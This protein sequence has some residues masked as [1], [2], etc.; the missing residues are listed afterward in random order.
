MDFKDAASAAKVA[1]ESAELASLAARA[2][3]ELSSRG[4]ISQ[5]SS[6]E[7][8]KSSSYNLR[9]EGPQGYASLNLRDQQLPKNQVISAP[10]KSSM[11]DD[12]WRD[13]DT[14]RFMGDDAKNF[15]YPSSSASNNDVNPSVTNFSAGDRY[16]FKNT[17]EPG[18]SDS[19]GSSATVEKQPRKFDANTS[20]TS[21]NAADR[22]SFKNSSEPGFSDSLDSVDKQP[23]RFDSNTS[24]SNSNE[25]DRYSLK[26]PSEP[27]FSDSLGSS[28]SME[29]QP[30]NVNVEYVND[31]SFGMGFERTSSYGDVRIGNDSNKV[32]SH[33]KLGNDTYE[34]P[35]AMDKPNDNEST[36]DTSFNDHASVV[37][38]DYGPD[39]DYIPDIDYHRGETIPELFSPKGKVPINSSAIDDTWI[40]KHNKNDSPEKSV[41]HSPISERTSLFAGNVGSFDEPSH[42]D[43]LLPATF[44]HS[45]GPSSK[46]EEESEES[47]M[48]GKEESSE[49]SKKQNLYS[50]KPEWTQN[51]SHGLSGSSDEENRSTPSRR[52]SSELPLVHESKKRDSPPSSPDIVHDTSI[53]EESTSESYSGF[54]FGKL[55]GGLR[56]QKSDTRRPYANNSSRSG[57]PSKQAYENDASKTEQSTSISSSTARTSFRS[58][59]SSVE[60]YDRS[61]EEKPDEEKS[62]R[63]K[64]NSFNSSLDDSKD[65]FSDYTLRSDQESQSNELVDEISK[66]PA[67]TR[68]AVKYPGFHDDDDFEE[69]SPGHNM[70]NS[71]R[72]VIGLSR[73]TKASPKSPSPYSEDSDRTPT[74]HEDV[75]ERKAS[76]SY[77]ASTSPLKENTRTRY[78]DRLEISEQPQSS[79]PF[80]QTPETKRSYN[81]E[82]LK[83]SAKEQQSNY[84]Q[85]LDRRGN[86]E[87]SKFSSSRDTTAASVKTRAQSSN[88]EQP[89]ST[90]PSKPIPETRRSFHEE[91]LTSSTKELPSHP[92]PKL[93]T[94]GNSESSKK[95]KTKAVEKASHVHPKLP[96]YDNFA[97]HFL[98]LRQNNK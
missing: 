61:V 42:S 25:S 50:E 92:S 8:Q 85:E 74:S 29:K 15:T 98:S 22:Y 43:D 26:N 12:N 83:S 52:L 94:Q 41:T 76:K 60:T 93:E 65:K 6:S 66:K 79:K 38:D 90:K 96:D 30:R 68:V 70:K 87:S 62:S 49:F 45:D 89:Q 78:S 36:V 17:S 16:S 2:A 53:S 97:A 10:C 14:R 32:P 81:E 88:S 55:K 82:R 51:I 7:Y 67:P 44:D 80:K 71:P 69:D 56:N 75:T 23:R 72:R 95:E 18:F 1:A 34:N 47:E 77:Y 28:T 57:L 86:F 35:F 13:N 24:V 48:I 5:P 54:N 20:V 4:N 84:P 31:Q 64:L 33:E 9:A 11:P 63:A 3:A 37:F 40:F 59:A 91:R 21:F 46:S 27:R 73:R 58:N 19:L 39:D